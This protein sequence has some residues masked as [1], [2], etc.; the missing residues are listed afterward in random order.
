MT[1]CGTKIENA[2][3]TYSTDY[4]NGYNGSN[5]FASNLCVTNDVNFGQDNMQFAKTAEGAGAFNIDTHQVLYSQNLFEKLYPASTTK[6]MTSLITLEEAASCNSEVTFKQEMVAE[7]SSM[8]LKVGEKVRLSDL[9]SGM[10]MA[11]GNDAANAAAYT[12]SGSPEKFSQRM[13]E[14]AKQ[15]GMTNTNFV[16][17]SGLDDDNHYSSA[18]DMALLM[19]YAL[20]NDDFANLTAKK[21]VTVEF[22]EPKS[23]KTAYANH[24]RLLSLYP[25]CTGGKTGY[26]TVAGRCLVSSAKKDGVTLVCVTLNDRN[27]WND[28]ISLYDY[29]FE[30][31]RG[32]DCKDADFCADIPCVGGDK[33]SVTVTGEKNNTIVLKREDCDKIKKKIF[34]DSF[35][36]APIEKNESVGRIE[37]TLGGKLLYKCNIVA[38]EK[39]KSDKKSVSIFSAIGNLFS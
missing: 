23:K 18:K 22:L 38:G 9:A 12:I 30:K 35:L 8:Y 37:Y 11:S 17:P 5:Y 32:V 16:T 7:G 14:K 28:H 39:I 25:Y 13:N 24:N 15:I 34:I 20:E 19:S 4:I 3:D 21:S 36:Y 2:Y 33:D 27:D 10:M 31:Y 6:I 26:T 1:G 29:A